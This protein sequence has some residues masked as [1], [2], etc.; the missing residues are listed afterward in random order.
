[1]GSRVALPGTGITLLVT[2]VVEPRN[3][4]ALFWSVD[5]TMATPLLVNVLTQRPYWTGGAFIAAQ[6]VEA[7][8]TRIDT[9]TTQVSFTFPLEIG[10]LT[11]TGA[12]QLPLALAG[13]LVSANHLNGHGQ[14]PVLISLTSTTGQLI[15][16]FAAADK[17]VSS[18][19][20]LLAVSLAVLAAV[21]VLLAGWLLTEQ[22][23]QE[24]GLLR[25]RGASRR[26]LALA[27][28][29]GSAL[30]VV[31]GAAAGAALAVAITPTGSVPLSWYLAG[32]E[33]LAALGGPVLMTVRVHR[34]YAASPRR[35]QPPG[36]VPAARRLVVEAGLVLGSV[37]GLLVLRYQRAS[38]GG[39]LYPSAAPVLLAIGVAVVVVRFYPLG[40]RAI[41]RLTGQRASA[42]A[43]L[44][45]ARAARAAGSAAL[46]AFALVL[47]L[48]LASF[49]GMV[50]S[51]VITGEVDASWQQAGADVVISEPGTVSDTLQRAVA[52]VPGV[53]HVSA[54]GIGTAGTPGG[55]EFAVLAV[56]PG[57]YAALLAGAPVPE[58]PARFAAAAHAGAV[59]ALASPSLPAGVGSGPVNMF[60]SYRDFRVR[61]I[62]RAPSMSA[63][64]VLAPGY[65][66]L[67][68]AALGS[69]APQPNTL[70]VS[71]SHLNQAAIAAAVARY[72]RG[73]TVVYRSRLLAGLESAPLQ[74]GA[75][76]AL[77]LGGA[78]AV[79]C[80][81]LI[82]LL[83]LLLSAPSR[84]L[85]LARMST[86][87]LSAR[88][89]RAVAVLEAMPQL[90]AVLVG[91]AAAAAGL[92]PLL[93]PALSLSVFTGSGSSVPVRIDP[94]W[95]A[96]AAASV[97]V[98][99]ILTLTG[100]TA[101]TSHNAARSV[102]MED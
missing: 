56:S 22:R 18:V 79:L 96:A 32:L 42:A 62:G 1:V 50:R 68:R 84:Q 14:I 73:A 72:G 7:L 58:P 52:A 10:N 82:L 59:P 20:D 30:A 51:A 11:W 78:A 83:S 49:A 97:L 95:L 3:P 41:L 4:A 65:L 100:Q 38:S 28:L 53:Q 101:V 35:D 60:G 63:L 102:R 37:G 86:M 76:V 74:H 90:L 88:Q 13:A 21:V 5:E 6:A 15:D 55:Q 48:A 8:Q 47:A 89:G 93:G 57:Q 98:L 80:G 27:I 29:G 91:G 31:P 71:G 85:T 26:Q 45:L 36:R 9:G 54:A 99:A 94:A 75:Y 25:A 46:P 23:R 87:G 44:G 39:D 69:A 67:P 17:S 34:G 19:I 77:A 70:L 81:L 92:G 66:V 61:V 33:V 43:F 12:Q 2:G 40:V 24:L 16:E 64:D